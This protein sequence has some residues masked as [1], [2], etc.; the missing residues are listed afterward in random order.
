MNEILTNYCKACLTDPQRKPYY[1]KV[2]NDSF[3]N[4]IVVV[5]D[6]IEELRKCDTDF[7]YKNYE[8][9]LRFTSED[10]KDLMNEG[11]TVLLDC[12]SSKEAKENGAEQIRYA[13]YCGLNSASFLLAI[14]SICDSHSSKDHNIGCGML[15]RIAYDAHEDDEVAKNAQELLYLYFTYHPAPYMNVD[16][17][18]IEKYSTAYYVNGREIEV[19]DQIGK[20]IP[21]WD[22]IGSIRIC[23]GWYEN[24]IKVFY[25]NDKIDVY[26]IPSLPVWYVWKCICDKVGAETVNELAGVRICNEVQTESSWPPVVLRNE[27]QSRGLTHVICEENYICYNDNLPIV[28]EKAKQSN[29]SWKEDEHGIYVSIPES[30][31]LAEVHIQRNLTNYINNLLPR[32]AEKMFTFW[33]D[34]LITQWELPKGKCNICYSGTASWHEN[35]QGGVDFYLPYDIVKMPSNIIT[36]IF[37][38]PFVEKNSIYDKIE[39]LYYD[40]QTDG[41]TTASADHKLLMAKMKIDTLDNIY[42]E[43]LF[44]GR[45]NK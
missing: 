31:N 1:K 44:K 29:L 12:G 3:A 45:I 41:M 7:Y 15:C 25:K 14:H 22:V 17:V 30:W 42:G 38:S 33:Y 18:E 4:F 40:L 28:F 21:D 9:G 34:D 24:P 16:E 10:L 27:P 19:A 26:A 35:A 32:I 2:T 39:R 8:K 6:S 43:K 13:A 20:L 36:F 37:T 11:L 23:C 5:S